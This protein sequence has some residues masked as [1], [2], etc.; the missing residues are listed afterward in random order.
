MEGGFM[1]MGKK[2]EYTKDEVITTLKQVGW[3]KDYEIDQ[4]LDLPPRSVIVKLFETTKLDDVWKEL[5]IAVPTKRRRYTK[6]SVSKALKEIGCLSRSKID[7][8]PD[9]PSNVTITK[10]FKTTQINDVWRELGIPFTPQ[11]SYTKEEVSKALKGIGWLKNNDIDQHPDLPSL[12]TVLKLFKTTKMNNVWNELDIPFPSSYTKESVAKALKEIGWLPQKEI[13]QHPN[14]PARTT[15]FRLFKTTKMNDVWNELGIPFPSN[16]TKEE[17]SKALKE[18]GW[19]KIKDIKQHPDLP[20]LTTVLRLFKTTK[21][22]NVWNELGI[23]FPTNYTKE[24]V[25]KTLKETGW[26]KAI[27]I[28]QH[29]D[30]PAVRTIVRLFK[31]SKI[32]DVWNELDIPF[33]SNYTKEEVSKALKEIGWIKI[34]DIKQHPDLPSCN[35]VLRLFKTT[36]INDVWNKLDIPFTP[37]PSYT[38]EEVS[39]ALKETGYLSKRK[40]DQ[41]PDLPARTTVLKLFKTTKMSDVWKEL[42]IEVPTKKLEL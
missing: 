4:R 24:T 30:L 6:E 11:P 10:L 21:M 8:H 35:T 25:S 26:L 19:I 17:V 20:S 3:I 7:R 9:L 22:N 34:K 39:K 36:K 27:E 32:D 38:K 18:I 42:T 1:V 13:H 12:T 5:G 29:P 41:H 37:Q 23:P 33:S 15:I 31:T 28:D 40:I 2:Q 16:Y 14:L